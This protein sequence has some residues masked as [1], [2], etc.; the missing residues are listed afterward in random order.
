M[1][2]KEIEEKQQ[3]IEDI[4]PYLPSLEET[5]K[6]A[7]LMEE[8]AEVQQVIGKIL[9]HGYDSYHPETKTTNRENLAREI[10]DVCTAIILIY[11]EVKDIIEEKF[12]NKE[13]KEYLVEKKNR[14][15]HFSKLNKEDVWS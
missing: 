14:Y 15:L 9:R 1:N 13:Y 11:T 3:L 5:E 10:V 2:D 7:V 12:D 8:C 6:L 4:E